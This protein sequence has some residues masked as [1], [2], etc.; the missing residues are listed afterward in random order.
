MDERQEQ[1]LKAIVEE[2]IKTAEPVA[3]KILVDRYDLDVSAATIRNDMA[4]LEA[5]GFI[6]QPHTSSG[7]VPTEKGYQDYIKK[8]EGGTW[9]LH[10]QHSAGRALREATEEAESEEETMRSLA[11][12]L[13][14]LTGD[15]VIAAYGPD[16]TFYTGVSSLLQKPD[17]QSLELIRSVSGFLD[18]FDEIVDEVFAGLNDQPQVMIG[19][20]NPFGPETAAVMVKCRLPN[21]RMAL[22]GLV[23][24]M[25]MDYQ[26]NLGLIDEVIDILKE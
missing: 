4:E 13:V 23:G 5:H 1:I 21:G 7:R 18:H 11:G 6:R 12:A 19:S 3:S 20:E 8:L 22:L 25:R 2:Y 10:K 26:K 24:P 17:F 14:R 16:R 15:M 9:K